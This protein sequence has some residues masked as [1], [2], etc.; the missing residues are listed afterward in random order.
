MLAH[1]PEKDGRS[2]PWHIRSLMDSEDPSRPSNLYAVVGEGKIFGRPLTD[3]K[4]NEGKFLIIQ[5]KCNSDDNQPNKRD[6][7]LKLNGNMALHLGHTWPRGTGFIAEDADEVTIQLGLD[8][9]QRNINRKSGEISRMVTASYHF[10]PEFSP[11]LD[12]DSLCQLRIK[13]ITRLS[14]VVNEESFAYHEQKNR[15]S[16]QAGALSDEI[17]LPEYLTPIAFLEAV[18]R[19]KMFFEDIVRQMRVPEKLDLLSVM[20]LEDYNQFQNG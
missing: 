6:L 15:R 13:F 5:L 3:E 9:L 14:G 10:P 16:I 11:W 19:V 1:L 2:L 17:K 4:M 7:W 20:G 18:D 8:V 12:L